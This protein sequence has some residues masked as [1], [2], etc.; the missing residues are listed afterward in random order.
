[1]VAPPRPGPFPCFRAAILGPHDVPGR[2]SRGL[3]PELR[4]FAGTAPAPPA[5]ERPSRPFL[6]SLR[7]TDSESGRAPSLAGAVLSLSHGGPTSPLTSACG[8]H[9]SSSS[10]PLPPFPSTGTAQGGCAPPQINQ[11]ERTGGRHWGRAHPQTFSMLLRMASVLGLFVPTHQRGPRASVR[12]SER[13]DPHVG[14]RAEGSAC[15][16]G[17]DTARSRVTLPSPPL[18]RGNRGTERL[19][20]RSWQTFRAAGRA[21]T[22]KK[23]NESN[24]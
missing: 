11:Q 21:P 14:I 7:E 23:G 3:S 13:R 4:T 6:P 8:G 2:P 1:M 18:P 17:S 24:E 16:R 19:T 5:T 9:P 22:N 20:P 12:L 10:W 15:S